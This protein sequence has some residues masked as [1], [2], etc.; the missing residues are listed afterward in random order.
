MTT[1]AER[2]AEGWAPRRELAMWR[3][4]EAGMRGGDQEVLVRERMEQ[5]RQD[6]REVHAQGAGGAARRASLRGRIGRLFVTLGVAIGGTPELVAPEGRGQP[7]C[8]GRAA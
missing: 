1:K 6:A 5:L 7:D 4:G 2:P 3:F 8:A